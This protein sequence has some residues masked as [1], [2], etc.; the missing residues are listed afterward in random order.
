MELKKNK[1][2]RTISFGEIVIFFEINNFLTSPITCISSGKI[3]Q[4]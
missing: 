4:I 3:L 2:N 1:N